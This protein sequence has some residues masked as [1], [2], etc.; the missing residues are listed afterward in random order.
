MT[1]LREFAKLCKACYTIIILYLREELG[2][3]LFC[4]LFV[5]ALLTVVFLAQSALASPETEEI[6]G[7]DQFFSSAEC[8]ATYKLIS[9]D[10][11]FQPGIE[12]DF[13]GGFLFCHGNINTVTKP[14]YQFWYKRE[15]GGIV[16][17]TVD[18]SNN[19]YGCTQII[20]YED[21][22]IAPKVEYWH[23]INRFGK[24]SWGNYNEIRFTVPSG[25]FVNT[26]EL[27]N[28]YEGNS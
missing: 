1:N 4:R 13:S 25:T 18:L 12:G 27:Q 6:N 24:Y 9:V 3:K 2:M 8:I 19:R 23:Y 20:V 22:T 21:D 28:L 15:D 16:P 26:Y 17:A 14:I 5:V 11:N 10:V 7:Y